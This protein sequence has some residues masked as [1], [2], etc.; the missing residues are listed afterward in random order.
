MG[1]KGVASYA[2]NPRTLSS[3]ANSFFGPLKIIRDSRVLGV[4][5]QIVEQ[6]LEIGTGSVKDDVSVKVVAKL[7]PK[8]NL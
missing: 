3:D 7:T 8:H 6:L 1:V 5:L 4:L 2:P